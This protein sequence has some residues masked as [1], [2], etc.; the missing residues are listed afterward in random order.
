LLLLGIGT[1]VV[2]FGDVRQSLDKIITWVRDLGPVGPAVLALIYIPA[3]LL[4]VPGSLLTLGAGFAFGLATGTVA[5]SLGSTAGA[6][7]AFLVG[8]F[9]TRNRVEQALAQ[10]PRFRA[11][12]RAVGDH[13]FRIVLLTR[14][15]PVFPYTVLNYA[16]GL[17]QVRWR[18]FLIASWLGMLPGTIV[19]VYLGSLAKDLTDLASGRE[20]A[21]PAQT[22]LMIIGLLATGVVTLTITRLARRA[23]A[24]TLD[25]SNV[26]PS[27]TNSPETRP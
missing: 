20:T 2:F 18:D 27:T 23:L 7:A 16:F 13:G 19:Y 8:R 21:G 26:I 17:T 12:D 1:A 22:A 9:L 10:S 3:A 14:L 15:S 24:Q 25:D 5:V 4:L 6:V 11:L